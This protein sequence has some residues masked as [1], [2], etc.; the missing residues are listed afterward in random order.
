MYAE[1]SSSIFDSILYDKKLDISYYPHWN[2]DS[3]FVNKYYHK[4]DLIDSNYI[5]YIIG[6]GHHTNS[7]IINQNGYLYQ[8]P[9]T[10]Y[11]QDSILDF[12]PGFESGNNSRFEREIGLECM[13]CHNAYPDFVLGS[14]N[15]FNK[16]PKN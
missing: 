10:F 3:L 16:I 4:F 7:H 5:D 6:S 2:N 15:K 1:Y 13:T 12:P 11:T 8:A 9:F 14:T